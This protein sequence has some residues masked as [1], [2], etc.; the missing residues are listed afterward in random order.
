MN[1]DKNPL[2]YYRVY[3]AASFISIE[4]FILEKSIIGAI[5]A[6]LLFCFIFIGGRKRKKRLL[7][8][9]NKSDL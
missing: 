9:Q 6:L 1:L 3:G 2:F 5:L 8:S 7:K 4:I